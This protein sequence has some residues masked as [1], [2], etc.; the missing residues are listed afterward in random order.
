[1]GGIGQ[2]QQAKGVRHHAQ[3]GDL[4]FDKSVANAGPQQYPTDLPYCHEQNDPTCGGHRVAQAFFHVGDGM[5]VDRRYHQ[6]GQPV[7]HGQ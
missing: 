3:R 6:Q 4:A 5:H 7:A 2:Q 1:M